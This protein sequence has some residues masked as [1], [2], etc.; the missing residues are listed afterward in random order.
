[1]YHKFKLTCARKTWGF[2]IIIDYYSF[3]GYLSSQ[4]PDLFGSIYC[5]LI[6]ARDYIWILYMYC[7]GG[8]E[9]LSCTP[10]SHSV[11]ACRIEREKPLSMGSFLMERIFRSTPNGVLTAHTEWLPGVQSVVAQWQSTGGSSQRSPGFDSR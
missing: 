5:Q 4:T 6:G 8:T 11:C 1:M 2:L 10:G 7:T 3:M 9:C